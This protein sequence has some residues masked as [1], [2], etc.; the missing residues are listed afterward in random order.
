MVIRESGL[1][2]NPIVLNFSETKS[3]HSPTTNNMDSSSLTNTPFQVNLSPSSEN[4][5]AVTEFD[6][7]KDYNNNDHT[8]VVVS[9]SAYADAAASV[10][11]IDRT[12]VPSFLDFKLCLGTGLDLSLKAVATNDAAGDQ[13]EDNLSSKSDDENTKNEMAVLRGK[14]ARMKKENGRL[15][16]M[17]EQLQT[18][19]DMLQMN[20]EK[21]MQGEKAEEVEEQEGFDGKIEK[22]RKLEDG[23]ASVP[24]DLLKLELAINA[25]VEID[26]EPSSSRTLS[27]D[28]LESPP[29]K[30]IEVSSTELVLSK[31]GNASDEEKEE[32]GKEIEREDSPIPH[33]ERIQRMSPPNYAPNFVDADATSR[34]A[35]VSV[36]TRSEGNTVSDG[37]QWRKYGQKMAKG[38]P[39]PR[40][41]Y[42]CTM[43]AGCPVR[44]QVQKSAED[45][46][47][48]VT[49]Y[50]GYHNH[51][52]PAAAREMAH[53]IAA[54][55]RMLLSGSTSSNDATMNAGLLRRATLLGSSSLAT[56]SA[57]APFP[58]ITLDFTQPPNPQQLQLLRNQLQ[59]PLPQMLNQL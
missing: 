32:D 58:T 41:Y 38:N 35:R 28:R 17:V 55:A 1:N 49:T 43:A 23:E 34:R 26:P 25:D 44:K 18:D 4:H 59:V 13:D 39:S 29:E 50:E 54:A 24:R 33:A 16:L 7:F 3:K 40:S 2:N 15:S 36:R 52:L 10:F 11:D 22:K 21:V 27:S 57:S 56:I 42:R 30:N 20:F 53:T 8:K 31:N 51:T 6:F 14:L 9:P 46:T 37:C 12:N 48:V 47:V 5:Q 19:Y 45:K